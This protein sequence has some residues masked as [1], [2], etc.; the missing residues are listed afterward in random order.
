MAGTMSSQK[1]SRIQSHS[2]SLGSSIEEMS[3]RSAKAPASPMRRFPGAGQGLYG[4]DCKQPP[5]AVILHDA[6]CAAGPDDLRESVP[7]RQPPVYAGEAL[8]PA[9]S[10]LELHFSYPGEREALEYAIVADERGNEL[11]VRVRKNVLRGVVLGEEAALLEDGDLV[12]HLY[13]LVY[14][15]GNED[16]GLLDVL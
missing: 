5:L 15:V 8:G 12:A 6:H 13:G 1:F 16:D 2:M 9:V 7:H 14:I 4:L 10:R 11:G 3:C